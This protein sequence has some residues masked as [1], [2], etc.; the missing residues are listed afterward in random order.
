MK[1]A[2]PWVLMGLMAF[3]IAVLLLNLREKDYYDGGSLT[4][5]DGDG[6]SLDNL[7]PSLV[8]P[9]FVHVC[10]TCGECTHPIEI[11]ENRRTLTLRDHDGW[12]KLFWAGDET[13]YFD[14]LVFLAACLE[15]STSRQPKGDWIIRTRVGAPTHSVGNPHECG[16]ILQEFMVWYALVTTTGPV[17]E[18]S[19][20]LSPCLNV[21]RYIQ[22]F[23]RPMR[24]KGLPP[25]FHFGWHLV[26]NNVS[27]RV[28]PCGQP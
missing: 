4:P 9:K 5:P 25:V 10:P 2:V 3:L 16:Q 28:C 12:Y 15:N 27:S 7:L 13:Y 20:E 21:P 6:P 18:G 22:A 11:V 8:P 24:A 26:D 14:D 19:A 17:R 1:R 23:A